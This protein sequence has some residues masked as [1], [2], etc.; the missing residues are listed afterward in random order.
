MA[1]SD[2]R[3]NLLVIILF[4]NLLN[5]Q[6]SSNP[7]DTQFTVWTHLLDTFPV[8]QINTEVRDLVVR[9][10]EKTDPRPSALDLVGALHRRVNS[11]KP[12][13][14]PATRKLTL[15]ICTMV[16]NDSEDPIEVII[17]VLTDDG[18]DCGV[19]PKPSDRQLMYKTDRERDA[20]GISNRMFILAI[21][22][23]QDEQ[24]KGLAAV[25]KMQELFMYEALITGKRIVPFVKDFFQC[26]MT[27]V[28]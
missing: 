10:M 2:N 28:E 4:N 7:Q 8:T 14:H 23:S 22:G 18:F 12:V 5:M 11:C 16:K 19:L 27:F 1:T 20:C 25:C 21:G 9:F 24:L 6:A 13:L 3:L 17:K 26:G 15:T